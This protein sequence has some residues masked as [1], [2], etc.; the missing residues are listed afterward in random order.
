M[1]LTQ[2]ELAVMVVFL[3][4]YQPSG[5]FKDILLVIVGVLLGIQKD[6]SGYNWGSSAGSDKKTDLLSIK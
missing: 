5:A 3:I 6:Y 4:A 1:L 2:T